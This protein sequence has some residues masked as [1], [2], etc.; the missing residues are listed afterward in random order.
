MEKEGKVKITRTS[1]S[2]RNA[3]DINIKVMVGD[4]PKKKRVYR[5]KPKAV[6]PPPPVVQNVVQLP[7]TTVAV[8]N[9]TY[10]RPQ[11]GFAEPRP[12]DAPDAGGMRIATFPELLQN[13]QSRQ[14]LMG[15]P[16]QEESVETV[17]ASGQPVGAPMMPE[18]GG[19][20]PEEAPAMPAEE[21]EPPAEEAPLVE[22]VAPL[23]EGRPLTAEEIQMIAEEAGR[24]GQKKEAL[25][26]FERVIGFIYD[27]DDIDVITEI[28]RSMFPEGTTSVDVWRQLGA[29]VQRMPPT[30]DRE[31]ILQIIM[32][33]T[34]SPSRPFAP[35]PPKK[36][37]SVASKSGSSGERPQ[38]A[39]DEQIEDLQ[40]Q[41]DSIPTDA[42]G[43]VRRG[44]KMV[45]KR[46]LKDYRKLVKQREKL[47]GR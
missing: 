26:A 19:E 37:P 11:Y 6:A 22:P 30:A 14:E 33:Q 7:P 18:E 21:E 1:A 34:P 31:A 10:G 12:Y 24:R 36:E 42:N 38:T 44:Y 41:I 15:M 17:D 28:S 20:M 9:I 39:L 27:T 2:A 47:R 43:N 8:P 4:Q 32:G 3:N 5:R 25:S 16:Q 46:L 40:G 23:P 13:Y 29:M 35:P 45:Q